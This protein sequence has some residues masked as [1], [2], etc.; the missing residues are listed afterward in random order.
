VVAAVRQRLHPAEVVLSKPLRAAPL[1]AL[2][3][4]LSACSSSSGGNTTAVHSAPSAP[5]SAQPTGPAITPA[6]PGALVIAVVG[7]YGGCAVDC[8][9]EQKVADMVHSWNP[10]TI[11][12]V[13]D[14]A[15]DG[16][17]KAAADMV[18][19]TPDITA[20]KFL[21]ALGNEDYGDTCNPNGAA[22]VMQVLRKPSHYVAALGGGLVDLFVANT[23]CGEPDGNTPGSPQAK[24]LQTAVAQ[25]VARWKIVVGHR[26]PFSSGPSHG[27]PSD[28]W[29]APPGTDLVLSG[30]DHNF[31]ELVAGATHYVI[32]GAGGHG[33]H[34]QCQPA[35]APLSQWRDDAHFG[36]VRL[37]ITQQALRVEYVAT[38]GI[39]LHTFTLRR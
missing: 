37:V 16:A 30:H 2:A 19:Y 8:S 5:A 38:G 32:D 7:D 28:S 18:P 6:P 33:L 22:A 12:S 17:A 3:A 31:E 4:L 13:G 34:P 24:Q 15:Y 9:E 23:E 26:S 29:L 20:G 14:N 36:A 39:V 10:A 21:G 1:L 11:I 25:S 35:C 27:T